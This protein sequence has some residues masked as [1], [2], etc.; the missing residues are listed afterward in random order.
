MYYY[1]YYYLNPYHVH[2][3]GI[4][5]VRQP[6][7]MPIP[8]GNMDDYS[9]NASIDIEDRLVKDHGKQPFT[10]DIEEATKENDTFRTAI[11]TGEHL[12]VTLMSI[13]VGEDIGLEIHQTTD[14]FLRL[15]DGEGV[16][17][18]GK[19]KDRL[20]YNVKVSDDDAIM[21][22]AGFWHNIV[23][24]GNEPLKLYS[25]YAPPEHRFGTVHQTKE[26]A[27]H[28]EQV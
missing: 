28:D 11:W 22:P 7:N 2:P 24:T 4:Y 18:M 8:Y 19:R 16:V 26:E 5:H 17:Q 10:L 23:N 27:I 12:Q 15:E 21:V 3:Y 25:I 20:D 14:Q 6:V 13:P 1:P 9:L